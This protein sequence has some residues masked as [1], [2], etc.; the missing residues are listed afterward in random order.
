MKHTAAVLAASTA[1]F[2]LLF[3]PVSAAPRLIGPPVR[4]GTLFQVP[5]PILPVLAPTSSDATTDYYD[6]TMEVGQKQILSSGELTTIWGYNGFYPG[7]TIMAQRGRTVVVRQVNHLQESM[8]VHLHGGHTSSDSDGLPYDLIGPGANKTYTYANNQ[9]AATLWYHDHAID[10]TGRHNY[11]GL[12]GFYLIHD[13]ADDLLGLPSGDY[14]IPLTI[15]D[16]LFNSDGSLNYPLDD[17]TIISGVFGDTLLVNGAIQPYFEVARRKYR[18]RIL[19]SSNAR[20]YTLALSSGDDLVQIASDGGLLAA[21]VSRSAI[22]VS[23][24]ERVEVV[25]DFANY[26]LGT[27]LILKNQ[28]TTAPRITDIMRFDVVRDEPDNSTVPAILRPELKKQ[29][30]IPG[31]GDPVER[32]FTLEP[33]TIDGRSVW[34]ING[35]LYDPARIDAAPHLN[36]TEIWTFQN[37]SGLRHPMH[38]HDIEWHILDINGVPPAPGDDGLKD[39]FLVPAHGTVRVM[40]TFTDYL[41]DYVSHCHNLEHEDHAMMFN[42][43]VQP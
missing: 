39:T 37:N 29:R 36:A 26:P 13:P 1:T 15:Q 10:V 17:N 4:E 5:L 7:P 8:S 12:S 20:I 25:I 34:T 32:T 14:D 16:R 23:P 28:D 21:P 30:V 35:Q 33:G 31:G 43:E 40:G 2:V 6:I 41:G 19:N 42:F 3:S 22:T 9:A 27:S 24:A 38:I 18:F 11:M